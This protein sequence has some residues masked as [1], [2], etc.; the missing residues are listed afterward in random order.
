MMLIIFAHNIKYNTF[1]SSDFSFQVVNKLSLKIEAIGAKGESMS[2]YEMV[3]CTTRCIL[4]QRILLNI[5]ITDTELRNWTIILHI[6][7]QSSF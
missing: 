7:Q 4:Q 1:L 5:N 3:L 6:S 2:F